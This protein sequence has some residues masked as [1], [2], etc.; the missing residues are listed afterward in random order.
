M[1]YGTFNRIF[2][3]EVTNVNKYLGENYNTNFNGNNLIN[4]G[5]EIAKLADG[6]INV[7][8]LDVKSTSVNL[9]KKKKKIK[10]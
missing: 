6:K 4:Q 2:P 9:S 8:P 1:W 5:D 10:L 7:L 3:E